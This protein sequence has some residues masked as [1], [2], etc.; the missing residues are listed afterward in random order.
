MIVP[1]FMLMR[2]CTALLMS[3][4]LFAQSVSDVQLIIDNRVHTAKQAVGIVVGTIGPSGT[5][6]YTSGLTS[7]GGTH[8]PDGQTLF[9]IG[10]VT[11]VFTSL[12][13]A[14]MIERGE[15]KADDPVSKY[16]PDGATVPS[17][18]GKPITLLNLSMQSS[19]LPL[20]SR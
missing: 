5:Q 9:A 7:T 3:E 16:L 6:I 17:H 4:L 1:S 18:N 11:K 2:V 13:L 8:K 12:L 14:D 15:V 10:S 19:G 20:R